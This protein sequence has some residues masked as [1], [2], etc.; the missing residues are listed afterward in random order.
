MGTSSTTQQANNKV[1][2]WD[3]GPAECRGS[4]SLPGAVLVPQ[5]LFLVSHPKDCPGNSRGK[6]QPPH[7]SAPTHGQVLGS[8][9]LG[10]RAT[11]V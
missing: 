9:L 10:Q 5:W 8:I 11:P 6:E 3:L 1:R 4:Q 7:H 2:K